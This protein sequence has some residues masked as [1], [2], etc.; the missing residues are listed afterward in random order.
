MLAGVLTPDRVGRAFTWL[1]FEVGRV[2][3]RNLLNAVHQHG[4]FRLQR[5]FQW[6]L[7]LELL[8]DTPFTMARR[9][10]SRRA[11]LDFTDAPEQTID[12]FM[13]DALI[14]DQ[15]VQICVLVR[16]SSQEQLDDLS[17]GEGKLLS[18][19]NHELADSFDVRLCEEVPD[20]ALSFLQVLLLEGD[21]AL[22]H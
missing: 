20:V 19:L 17:E 15:D 21:E 22:S 4:F 1:E 6:L 16:I 9:G 13:G 11:S 12:D 3:R 2:K 10:R 8:A 18:N 5:L 14:E 7:L